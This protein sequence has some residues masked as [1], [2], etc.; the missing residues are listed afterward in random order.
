MRNTVKTKTYDLS[1]AD[2]MHFLT[3]RSFH[4][5]K[6]VDV[7]CGEKYGKECL[8][9]VVNFKTAEVPP[10]GGNLYEI[11]FSDGKFIQ[12]PKRMKDSYILALDCFP[13]GR[14]MHV[15][16]ESEYFVGSESHHDIIEI[17]FSDVTVLQ[18]K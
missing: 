12:R 7:R 14:S 8:T 1:V 3:N 13:A 11:S 9:L 15:K 17:E 4:D 10:M 5:A 16:I 6:L 18:T 2:G